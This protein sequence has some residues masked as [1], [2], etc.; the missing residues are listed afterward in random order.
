MVV[1][2]RGNERKMEEHGSKSCVPR[3]LSDIFASFVVRPVGCLSRLSRS[4]WSQAAS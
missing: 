3:A 4:D 1:M 2:G